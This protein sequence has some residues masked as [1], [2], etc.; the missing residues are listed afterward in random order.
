MKQEWYSLDKAADLLGINREGI[1]CLIKAKKLKAGV[2][3]RHWLGVWKPQDAQ[4][5]ELAGVRTEKGREIKSYLCRESSDTPGGIIVEEFIPAGFWYVHS[6]DIYKMFAMSGNGEIDLS[7]IVPTQEAHA[8]LL[9]K[10]E[11]H[12]TESGWFWIRSDQPNR[13]ISI[14]DLLIHA[15]DI[16]PK[17]GKKP[18]D[19]RVDAIMKA[20]TSL[21]IDPMSPVR[22]DRSLVMN[23]AIKDDDSN[24][25][26]E[27]TAPKAYQEC[28]NR[29]LVKRIM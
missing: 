15:D 20:F 13:H 8:A 6:S 7:L 11:S 17:Q 5:L 12:V 28:I 29:Q 3:A 4:I 27:S 14:N 10:N 2:F 24:I 1:E 22:G 18:N 19:E 25:I 21:E 26:T 9:D 16:D 23:R